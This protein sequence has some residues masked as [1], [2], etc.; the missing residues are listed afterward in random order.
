MNPEAQKDIGIASRR[1]ASDSTK[2]VDIQIG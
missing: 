2:R 1:Y